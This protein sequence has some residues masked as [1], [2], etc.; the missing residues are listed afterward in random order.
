M[1][2]IYSVALIFV[3]ILLIGKGSDWL[4]DSLIPIAKRLGVSGVSIGLI[5][6]SVAVSLP[7]ILIA[8]Y[9]TLKGFSDITLGVILGSIFV[10]IGL[11]TGLSAIIRPLKVTKNLI[12]RD[13]VFSLIVPIL[14]LA[15]GMQGKITRAEGFA[16]VLLFVTYM[17][18]VFLQEKQKTSEERSQDVREVEVS[19]DLLGFDIGKIKSGWISF[20]LGVGVLLAGAQIFGSQLIDIAEGFQINQLIIGF[21]LG[22]IGPSIPNIMAAYKAAKR[23]M[24]EIAVSET[25]GSN[26]FT[27]LVTLGVTAMIAPITLSAQWITFDLPALLLLSGMLFIFTITKRVISRLEGSLLLFGYLVIVTMQVLLAL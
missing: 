12:L 3:S 15:V 10:N 17:I 11:M 9:T 20:T 22:A 14:V 21:T 19:L 6:V 24:G 18:N 23:D 8:V 13:G 5:L 16:F 1:D 26:I 7:E 2:M 27:L 25:L 4:T